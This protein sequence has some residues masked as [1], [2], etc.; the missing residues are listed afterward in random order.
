MEDYP[1]NQLEFET[2]FATEE[3]CRDYLA[4]LRWPDGFRCPQCSQGK[5]WPVRGGCLQCATC[6]RQTSVTAGTLLHRSK[7]PLRLWFRA[8][9][10]VTSQKQGASALGL[11]R[12]LG[13]GSYRTAWTWLHKL[14]RAMVRPG[15]D[16]LNGR[17]EVDETYVGGAEEGVRGRQTVTKALVAV[18]VEAREDGS[19]I[20]RIRMRVVADASAQSLLEFVREV[21]EPGSTV[22]TDGWPSYAQLKGLGYQHE[23]TV[24]GNPKLAGQMLPHV[25]RVAALFKR[26]WIGTHQGAIRA[27]HLDYYLDEFSFRFNRRKSHSRGKLFYRLAQHAAAIEPVPYK[28][29]VGGS[30]Q[31]KT[32]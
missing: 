30:L 8:M 3:A 28:S 14:R 9:W 15:Q 22:H 4:W 1:R 5:G 20:G 7:Q 26:W 32:T 27:R 13:L 31:G 10:W 24:L 19:G 16:R 17:V 18:A 29:I 23:M 25:H 21:V 12:V 2:R 11:Q 6:G